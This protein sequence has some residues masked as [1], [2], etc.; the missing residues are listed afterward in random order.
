MEICKGRE[1]G[2]KERWKE[3]R[4]K[5]REGRTD[6]SLWKTK[7]MGPFSPCRIMAGACSNTCLIS[8]KSMNAW[9]FIHEILILCLYAMSATGLAW[10]G[11]QD[12]HRLWSFGVSSL[13]GEMHRESTLGLLWWLSGK[14]STCQWRRH[15]FHTWPRS[16]KIPH[17]SEQ[18]SL[19]TTTAE[20]T[21]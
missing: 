21:L 5:Q 4:N 1:E 8:K 17:A 14:E 20:P 15:G 10:G 18:L 7:R 12:T 11:K 13:E 9:S 16:R 2:Q 3:G 6:D 19:W